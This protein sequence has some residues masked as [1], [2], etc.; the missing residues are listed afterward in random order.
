M[1]DPKSSCGNNV[2]ATKGH[3]IHKEED[4][5]KSCGMNEKALLAPPDSGR[6]SA[7]VLVSLV[8]FRGQLSF[9]VYFTLMASMRKTAKWVAPKGPLPG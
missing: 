1:A 7:C 8:P 3:R 4:A 5:C 9:P 2:L 6:S